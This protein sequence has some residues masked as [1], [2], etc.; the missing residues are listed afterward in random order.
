VPAPERTQVF[1]SYSHRDF[2]WLQRLQTMLTPLTRNHT[3][4]VW[5][6]THIKAGSQWRDE[7][8]KALARAKVAVLLVSPHF[9]ASEFIA[10]D[11]LPPLLKAAEKGG[12]TILWIAVSASLYQRTDI[13]TYQAANNPARPLDALRPAVL[14]QE[15]VKIAEMI[16]EAANQPASHAPDTSAEPTP[17]ATWENASPP[18]KPIEPEMTLIPAGEFLMGSDAQQDRNAESYEEPQHSLYLPEFLLAKTPVTQA[19]YREFVRATGHKAPY[20][21]SNGTPPPDK[22]DHP[23]VDVSWYDAQDYCQWLSEATGKSY[24]LPSEAEWEKGARGTDGRLYPWGN[25]WDSRRCNSKEGRQGNTTPMGAYLQGVSPYGVLDMVGNVWEWTS[26]LWGMYPYPS[27]A[28]ERARRED[29][30]APDAQARMLRGGA[31]DCNRGLV[32]CACRL[33]SRPS[34][35]GEVIGFRVVLPAS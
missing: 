9:L 18:E 1:I 26:S 17:E 16:E 6:D 35:S 8:E 4:T 28:K 7:I 3:I 22:E 11:E 13:A 30:Q 27:D 15:L 12:L 23:V 10:N 29:L 5:D 14:N 32:R 34:E 21:W 24:S 33:R 20:G 2:R 25:P 19:Q 31:F